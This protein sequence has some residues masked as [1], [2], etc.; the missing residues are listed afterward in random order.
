MGSIFAIGDG[1]AVGIGAVIL[2]WA[3]AATGSAPAAAPAMPPNAREPDAA[4]CTPAETPLFTCTLGA[5][6]ASLC[7]K[8]GKATYRY[9][10]PGQIELASRRLTMATRSLSGGGETQ[11]TAASNGHSHTMFDR[12]TRTAFGA[13]GR[14]DP[15]SETGLIVRHGDKRLSSRIC[16]NDMPISSRSRTVIPAGP[17]VPH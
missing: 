16:E 17:F 9:G 4:L 12:T 10:R 13:D 7:A 14:N 15:K 11:I 8:G 6:R 2:A 1:V 5:H 3:T